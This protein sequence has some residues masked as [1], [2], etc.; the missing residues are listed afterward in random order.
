MWTAIY[1]AIG[2]ENALDVEKKLKNE[3]FLIKKRL[4]SLEGEDELYEIIA[5]EF[6]VE[7]IQEAMLELGII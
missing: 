4:F 2:I 7:E 1:V 3:G 6:E 5:P